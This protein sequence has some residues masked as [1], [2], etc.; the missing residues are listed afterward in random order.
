MTSSCSLRYNPHRFAVQ[1]TRVDELIHELEAST[2]LLLLSTAE[3]Q[4]D[5]DWKLEEL[6]AD[7]EVRS[8]ILSPLANLL[9]S[10]IVLNS[11][12]DF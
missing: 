11:E 2:D 6:L 12:T 5:S 7:Q 10:F 9:Y 1:S 4:E 8:T 3:K